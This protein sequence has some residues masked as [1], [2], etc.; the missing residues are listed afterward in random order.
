MLQLCCTT[1]SATSR[2]IYSNPIWPTTETALGGTDSLCDLLPYYTTSATHPFA[3]FGKPFPKECW[4]S[5]RAR[6]YSVSIIRSELRTAIEDHDLNTNYGLRAEDV[7]ALVQG[8]AKAKQP[9]F[10]RDLILVDK[11]T[12]TEWIT[13]SG[14]R[15]MLASNT[16]DLI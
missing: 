10:W 9:I 14:T 8:T 15:T 4:D 13:Y 7:A 3:R 1:L 11:W 2:Q 6:D 16:G 5:I 12:Q